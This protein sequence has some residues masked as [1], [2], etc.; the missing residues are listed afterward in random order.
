MLHR[1]IKPHNILV[2]DFGE[3]LVVDWGLAKPLGEA[4][5]GDDMPT[6]AV[7]PLRVGSSDVTHL[8]SVVGTPNYMS[9]EQAQGDLQHLG[10]AADVFSLGATLYCLLTNQSP[11]RGPDPSVVLRKAQAC[12]RPDVLVVNPRVPRPLAAICRK[13]MA[14]DADKRYASARDLAK[15]LER[16][17]A[18]EPVAAHRDSW[19]ERM[20]RW[21]RKHRAAVRVAL[22][23]LVLLAIGG[24][25]AAVLIDQARRDV[26]ASRRL[27]LERLKQTRKSIDTWLTTTGEALDWD[28]K[29]LEFQLIGPKVQ[30]ARRALLESAAKEYERLAAEESDDPDL[31]IERARAYGRLGKIRLLSGELER[32]ASEHRRAITVLAS[33]EVK[34]PGNAEC[35]TELVN[36]HTQLGAA[37]ASNQQ[38]L[39][40]IK[41]YENALAA[42]E[43]M[44]NEDA[45]SVKARDAKAAVNYN[46]ARAK[47]EL[48]EF[49]DAAKLFAEAF[50]IYDELAQRTTARTFASRPPNFA[51]APRKS[52]WASADIAPPATSFKQLNARWTL[53]YPH[54]QNVPTS[55]NSGRSSASWRRSPGRSSGASAKN[56]PQTLKQWRISSACASCGLTESRTGRIMRFPCCVWAK[57]SSVTK[58][59]PKRGRRSKR[60]RRN[61]R[62]W[63]GDTPASCGFAKDWLTATMR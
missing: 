38:F 16:W 58:A 10:P 31:E 44:R 28:T 7:N 48:R 23:A 49:E 9:P 12:D 59:S 30:D 22:V 19:W 63:L 35:L 46:L 39:D 54:T 26:V 55:S 51:V 25:T 53:S 18:D 33:V 62:N 15:D 29:S 37:L 36:S 13:A 42:F 24:A 61:T 34:W 57:C 2:G 32:A 8:G 27:A 17:L 11:Y 56:W 41:E 60:Q 21:G 40:A 45:R 5:S 50:S 47:L 20:R 43:Q 4:A 14:R 1:D 3:T 52:T 6:V